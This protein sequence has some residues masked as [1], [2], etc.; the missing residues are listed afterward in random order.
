[1]IRKDF[2]L[3]TWR[4]GAKGTEEAPAPDGCVV[5]HQHTVEERG[6]QEAGPMELAAQA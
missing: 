1:M 3:H 2:Q 4:P 6:P 5:C